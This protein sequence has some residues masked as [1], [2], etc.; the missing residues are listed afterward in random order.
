[1]VA[2]DADAA[3]QLP[4]TDRVAVKTR[5]LLTTWLHSPLLRVRFDTVYPR[6][7]PEATHKRH[8]E[9]PTVPGTG[10]K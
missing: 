2:P 4:Q 7:S 1:M 8:M 3:I 6:D 10:T 9:R 5:I